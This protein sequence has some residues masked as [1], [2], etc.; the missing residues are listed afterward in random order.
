MNVAKFIHSQ[1][2]SVP[3]SD[4][5]EGLDRHVG[6]IDLRDRRAEQGVQQEDRATHKQRDLIEPI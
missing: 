3:R 2:M 1:D 6:A 4:R 5:V